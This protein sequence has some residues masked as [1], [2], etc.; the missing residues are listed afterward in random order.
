MI[1]FEFVIDFRHLD[2]T[3]PK[4]DFPLPIPELMIDVTTGYEAMSFMDGCSGYNQIR[5]ALKDEN[6]PHFAH[7]KVFTATK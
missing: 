5:M 3:C 2:N 4:D 7:R 6:S 1:K